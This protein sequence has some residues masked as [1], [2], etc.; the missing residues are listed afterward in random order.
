MVRHLTTLLISTLVLGIS[1]A[2]A[3]PV[4]WKTVEPWRIAYYPGSQACQ[5]FAQ[6]R[7]H[8]AFFIGFDRRGEASALDVT[9]LDRRWFAF[10]NG[11]EYRVRIRFDD[12]P[13]W[14]LNMDGVLLNGLPGLHILIDPKAPDA[15]QF[16]AQF[17]SGQVMEWQH[18]ETRLGRFPLTGSRKAFEEVEYCQAHH[19]AIT[20]ARPKRPVARPTPETVEQA[21]VTE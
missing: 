17:Q 20:A 14:T 19:D 3:Q 2:G 18:G 10:E 11:T 9:I 21:V 16:I 7:E 4:G 5:A 12:Q 6:Y 15:R 13:V 1:D 8:T